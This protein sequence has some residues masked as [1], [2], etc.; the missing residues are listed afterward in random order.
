MEDMKRPDEALRAYRQ[1]LKLE[2]SFADAHY[3][4]GLLLETLG[5]LP[6]AIAHLRTAR[7][8]YLSS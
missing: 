3:N 7:K 5:K 2:P 6:E 1:T 4:L 8:I